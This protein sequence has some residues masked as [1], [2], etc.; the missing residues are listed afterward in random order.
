MG[1]TWFLQTDLGNRALATQLQMLPQYHHRLGRMGQEQSR[2]YYI[3][4]YLQLTGVVPANGISAADGQRVYQ[5]VDLMAYFSSAMEHGLIEQMQ[6]GNL[7]AASTVKMLQLGNTNGLKTFLANSN[8]WSTVS[9]QLVNYDLNGLYY[10]ITNNFNLLLSANGAVN[11]AG[12]GSWGGYGVVAIGF[13]QGYRASAML[14]GGAY[15]G[16]YD[17]DPNATVDP[18]WTFDW[19]SDGQ[20]SFD[21]N[22]PFNWDPF[23]PEPVDMANGA[24]LLTK[25]DLDLGQPTPRGISFTRYYSSARR[26]LNSAGMT[27]GWTHNCFSKL[28]E[29][30]APELGLGRSTPA[31]MAPMLV[32]TRAAL[33]LYSTQ[34]NAKNWLVTA[35][36]A[37]WGIDQLLD[38]SVS[39]TLGKDTMQFIRQP[40]GAFTPPGNSTLTLLKTNSVYWLQERHGNIFKFNN[41]GLLTNIV[42]QYNQ[43]LRLTY[44]TGASSNWVTQVTDWK[45]R[46]LTLAYSGSP[47]R[48][49]SISDSTGRSVGFGYSTAYS[50][51][52]DLAT[53]TDPESKTSTLIYDADHQIVAAKDAL[54]QLVV[55]NAYDGFGRVTAQYTQGDTNK[56]WLF[57]WSDYV[58][59]E[60]DPLGSKRR[61]LFDEKGRQIGVQDASGNFSQTFFDGQD[62][63]VMTIS[64]LNET[65][66]FF[67]DGN[68]NV[69]LS[70]DPLGFTN[71]AVYDNQNNLIRMIDP[72]ANTNRFG[73]NAKFQITGSTNGAGDWVTYGYNATDGTLTNRTDVGGATAYSY[74]SLGQLNSTTYPGSLGSETYLS[75]TRGDVTNRTN[76][77]GFATTLQYN[78][79]RELTNTI[80][81]TNLTT[82]I[83]RDAVGNVASTTDAR[84]LAT[85]NIWSP[86]GKLLA[87]VLPAVPQGVPVVTNSY[88][89]RDW[90]SRTLNPLQQP[91]FYTNDLAGRVV[92]TTDPLSRTTRFGYDADARRVGA[93]NAALE[94]TKQVWD[95]RGQL[96]Q[97]TDAET[98][99]VSRVYDPAGNQIFLTNR[100][101]KV[102]RFQYDAANRLTNTITPLNRQIAQSWNGRGLLSSIQE[103]STQNVTF[104]YDARGRL[105]N[106]TDAVG[107]TSYRYDANNNQTNVVEAGKTN[108]WTF[109]AYDRVSSY[110]DSD[111]N[112]IQYRNDANG[113]VTNLIYPGG[114]TVAYFYDSLNRLTNVTDWANRKTTFTYNLANRLTSITRPNGTVREMFFDAAGQMTNLVERL[115]NNAPVAFFKLNWNSAA[116]IEWEF[117]AP[118]PHPFTPP[119]RV[120]TYD[121]DNRIAT[122]NS[123]NVVHDSDGNMTSSP[124]TNSTFISYNYDARNRLTNAA[125]VTYT[126][127]P[128]GNRVAVSNATGITKLVINPNAALSQ[129]LMR[130][131]GGVTNYYV[132]GLGLLYQVTETATSTSTLTY[133]YDLR[134]S[135]IALTDGSGNPTDR[136]EYSAY[137]M[138]T[139]RSGT[140]DT[141][142]LFNGRF[143]VQTDPNGLLYM[144]ARYYNPYLCRFLNA[145]PLMFEGGLNFYV[146]S[147]GNPISLLDPFGL[148]AYGNPVSGPSGPVGPSSPYAPGGGYYPDGAFYVPYVP[149]TPPNYT[150]PNP[151][152]HG[153]I[154]FDSGVSFYA[155]GGG[156]GGTQIILLDNGQIVSYGYAGVG[157]GLGGGG[158][159]FGMGEVYGVYQASDYAGPF[160]NI[161]A[162]LGGGGG[163]SSWPGGAA[164]YTAGVATAG[165]N[166]GFQWYWIIDASAPL[167]TPGAPTTTTSTGGKP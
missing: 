69:I 163:L 120:M 130:T 53:S 93:T 84:G 137:G 48:L 18:D 7:V 109:D 46:T 30:S 82:R 78:L 128:A 74:D 66:Q 61:F 127:D 138:T 83:A 20:Y 142:F 103:P 35:L 96:T 31:Q 99:L 15:F 11:I 145:D 86:T 144:R 167:I 52:G 26:D 33:E 100:N 146:Y 95:A 150:A 64:P 126:Y 162:G 44:G 113:N 158:G 151:T 73:Y 40:N 77:R 24:F 164:S 119:T 147:D 154:L 21:P 153:M 2:G 6:S 136:I 148:S 62:H 139:Y 101:G 54:N 161:G 67:Y 55:S 111:G 141:P 152:G 88:D 43:S 22:G 51:Q 107:T 28:S 89:V 27:Y 41:K 14:I 70:V 115:T 125:G 90:L 92:A 140:N 166:G 79:R 149:T 160:I 68:H 135:T 75:N 134:G 159:G 85:T 81:P 116:R 131:K 1:M 110:R 76:A 34:P 98:R 133:H 123:Q 29:L 4:T 9:P 38:N 165:V 8:N 106:R 104:N 58:T 122:F 63:P 108:S 17:S 60:Q 23:S 105:T 132:Y 102:W 156:G 94:V 57:L 157:A 59:V 42:D 80:T 32:A 72:R 56:A 39:I 129:V 5:T 117:A 3:D 91:T 25:T 124:L 37:K 13:P 87:T 50:S 155:L 97:S 47:L 12:P 10:F 45:N 114:K 71:Q 16:G 112:L 143:G 36:I 118:L 19:G 121:D 65:N 49:T